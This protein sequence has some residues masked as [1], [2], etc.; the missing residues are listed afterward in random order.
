MCPSAESDFTVSF[1]ISLR[2]TR[3]NYT[4]H[5]IPI[6]FPGRQRQHVT[7]AAFNRLK[8]NPPFPAR[9]V[10]VDITRRFITAGEEGRGALIIPLLLDRPF[11]TSSGISDP[12]NPL[13]ARRAF[14]PHI[15]STSRSTL[16]SR[17]EFSTRRLN[18]G[19][20]L[21]GDVRRCPHVPRFSSRGQVRRFPPS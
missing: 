8:L 15:S 11:S 16:L 20:T 18:I 6:L 14:F 12:G 19:H 21:L 4:F 2:V 17:A 9:I 3:D 5:S 10:S 13:V 7:L 1:S